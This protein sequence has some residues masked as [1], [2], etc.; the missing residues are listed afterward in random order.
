MKIKF[1]QIVFVYASAL[2][3]LIIHWVVVEMKCRDTFIPV[4]HKFY[5]FVQEIS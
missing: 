2:T 1:T 4:M 5:V 3:L